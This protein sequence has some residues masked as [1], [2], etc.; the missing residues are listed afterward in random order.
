M[1]TTLEEFAFIYTAQLCV[2][3]VMKQSHL[4]SLQNF[5]GF[6]INKYYFFLLL[7]V[8]LSSVHISA[9]IL[10]HFHSC[11]AKRLYT[12]NS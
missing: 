11:L 7:L 12:Q 5:F 1:V 10:S 2:K 3:F 8:L 4:E 9:P 6:K